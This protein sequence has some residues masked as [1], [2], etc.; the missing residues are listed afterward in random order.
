[1][2]FSRACTVPTGLLT[3]AASISTL[4]R[5]AHHAPTNDEHDQE[6]HAQARE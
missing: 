2:P 4:L 1:M 5:V 3:D 6:L